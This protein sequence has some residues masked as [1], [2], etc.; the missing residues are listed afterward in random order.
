MNYVRWQ[1]DVS[2]LAPFSCRHSDPCRC[3]AVCA[4]PDITSAVDTISSMRR[5]CLGV[6][7][8]SRGT[9]PSPAAVAAGREAQSAAQPSARCCRRA[10]QGRPPWPRRQM[11]TAW[12]ASSRAASAPLICRLQPAPMVH[13]MSLHAS[14]SVQSPAASA[15]YP[16]DNTGRTFDTFLSASARCAAR[17]THAIAPV[18]P[19]RLAGTPPRREQ[20]WG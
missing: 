6:H 1:A 18:F 9:W 12:A 17:L 10:A 20:A 3:C 2:H 4:N 19:T 14:Q 16:A 11:A 13:C 8:L 7:K 5:E 15:S